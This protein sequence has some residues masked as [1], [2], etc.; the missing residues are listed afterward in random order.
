MRE[1]YARKRENSKKLLQTGKGKTQKPPRTEKNM[2]MNK[3]LNLKTKK[4][5]MTWPHIGTECLL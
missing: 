3:E 5:A 2:A 4:L 1:N